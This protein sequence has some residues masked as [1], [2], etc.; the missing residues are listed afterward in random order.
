MDIVYIKRV[1]TIVSIIIDTL[2]MRPAYMPADSGLNMFVLRIHDDVQKRRGK[3][4]LGLRSI[5]CRRL[6][7]TIDELQQLRAS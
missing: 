5:I 2:Y 3:R 4:I 6:L 7:G 1:D